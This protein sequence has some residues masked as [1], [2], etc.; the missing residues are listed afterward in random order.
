MK[1]KFLMIAYV[2]LIACSSE[3]ENVYHD[4]GK[5]ECTY[6][7]KND[8]R[9]GESTCF[10]PSGKLK[11]RST[12]RNGKQH[13]I[14]ESYFEN[15]RLEMRTVWNDGLLDGY[16]EQ[17]YVNGNPFIKTLYKKGIKAG[18]VTTYYINAK[19]SDRRIADSLGN[20]IYNMSWNKD[21]SKD[22]SRVIPVVKID[23]DTISMQETC[24]INVSF[25]YKLSGHVDV[26]LEG[27][28]FL[29]A[30]EIESAKSYENEFLLK[31]K[32]RESGSHSFALTVNHEPV[33]GDTLSADK[34]GQ[35]VKIV[36]REA[37]H[38]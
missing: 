21:G 2:V 30:P 4:N 10:Y 12:Y 20:V 13:G 37:G 22:Y 23:N 11:S 25:G 17:Y 3:R 18:D 34:T 5:L 6:E 24:Y 9:H 1:S 27:L 36:V 14:S 26:R 35:L 31:L 29:S 8:V 19:I 28:D 7:M 32:F 33:K 15:G 38:S 16:A